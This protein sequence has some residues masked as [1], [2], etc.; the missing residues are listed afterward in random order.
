MEKTP[1]QEQQLILDYKGNTVVTA[2]PGSGKTF[3][4]VEKIAKV[5]VTLPDYKGV[6]AISFTNKASDE[7]KKRC[8]QK[9]MAIGQSFYGT[10][11]KFYISQ[12]I[13]PFANHLTNCNPEYNILDSFDDDPDYTYLSTLSGLPC[14]KKQEQLIF[15]SL[16]KG[17]IFLEKLGEFA[18]YILETVPGAMK[19]L[20]ARYSYIFIDEYQDCGEIQH[21]IFLKLVTAGITGVAVGD[22]NQAIYG[23]AN[24][25]PKYLIE[26]IGRNDFKHFELT[27]NHR[28][29]PSISEYSL[30]L[31]GASK[32]LI[33]DKR[34][35]CVNIQGNEHMI[36]QQIDKRIDCIKR[37]YGV[38]KNN[39][40]AILCRGNGTVHI[41]DASLQTK[42]KTFKDTPL[43]KDTS[44]WCRLFRETLVA[45]FAPNIY[46]VDFAEQL[47]S[48]EFENEK[49]QNALS[50][51]HSIF[52]CT[53]E[54][55]S[56]SEQSFIRLAELVYPQKMTV[57][58]KEKLH[59]VLNDPG[60]IQSYIPALE[61][62][63]N[64]MTIH[65]S[66]GLEFNIVFHMD[67]YRYIISDDWGNSEDIEQML[68]LHYVGVTRAIDVCYIM[69]GT[70]RYSSKYNDY[71]S[72]E[73]S[74][75]L[76]KPGLEE[77][78]RDVTWK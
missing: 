51:C 59:T 14:N 7:L 9:G 34:V 19:Y 69:E 26:L 52:S 36:A 37:R 17:K 75:F 63:I 13:I 76:F 67:M 48:E 47:F 57:A 40:I 16:A 61:D 2:R 18:L 70:E 64:I 66:K 42:H 1:T 60:L 10:I 77:R 8:S 20:K 25:F 31:Y 58:S 49:Y 74:S 24:R 68:N 21:L 54:N 3:T 50:I 28:C 46:A 41:L 55:I 12:I 5:C 6:I 4:V 53:Q 38:V 11:D 71:I 15:D 33:A 45:C 78:R 22:I 30:C 43:D 27:K 23:F 29:H 73:P 32:C 35:F 62:E 56:T 65:K 72:A 39:Q 44:E